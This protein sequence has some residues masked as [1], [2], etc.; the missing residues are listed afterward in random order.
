MSNLI[1]TKNAKIQVE[2]IEKNDF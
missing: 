1:F 2:K